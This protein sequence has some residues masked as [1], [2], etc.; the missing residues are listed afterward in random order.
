LH[1]I[2]VR[3][4]ATRE[5]TFNVAIPTGETYEFTF[6]RDGFYDVGCDIHP[7]MTATIIATATPYTAIPD[8]QGQ[9]TMS[10]VPPGTYT[11]TVHS[12]GS[13]SQHA[14]KVSGARTEVHLGGPAA[15][16]ES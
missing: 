10:D 8:A 11:A 15:A 16:P 1:N 14:V 7:G 5:G 9:F 6:E 12:G 2:R 4:E 13:R 3:E